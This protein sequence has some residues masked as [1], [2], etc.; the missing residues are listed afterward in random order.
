MSISNKS[1][2][3][4]EIK[5][6]IR[7]ELRTPSIMS[8][9]LHPNDLETKV[10]SLWIPKFSVKSNLTLRSSLS[11]KP[12][13]AEFFSELADYSKMAKEKVQVGEIY[14]QVFFLL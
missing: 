11:Q 10:L 9:I 4:S 14:H 2:F 1:S 12:E 3:F 13:L 5:N 6:F 8:K 7:T